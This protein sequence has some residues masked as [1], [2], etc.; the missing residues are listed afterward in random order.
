[1]SWIPLITK[2]RPQAWFARTENGESMT[3]S[4]TKGKQNLVQVLHGDEEVQQV[5]A[6]SSDTATITHS[7]YQWYFWNKTRRSYA[8]EEESP[9]AG[10]FDWHLFTLKIKIRDLDKFP[11]GAFPLFS[12]GQEVE[13]RGKL[14]KP[15]SGPLLRIKRIWHHCSFFTEQLPPP[16]PF[17]PRSQIPVIPSSRGRRNQLVGRMYI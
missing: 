1:M 10:I 9:S 2:T 6:K 4:P 15:S 16:H 17:L 7:I 5:K 14:S 8:Y 13:V 11:N 12:L 3:K